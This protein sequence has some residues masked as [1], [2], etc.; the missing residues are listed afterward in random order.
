MKIIL[1]EIDYD[2]DGEDIDL[3]KEIVTSPEE[4]GYDESEDGDLEEY[5]AEHG[6]DYI[7]DTTGWL[8][9]G[10]NFKIVD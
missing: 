7:S 5:I 3:P 1:S 9:E 6:A 10:F 4:M 8:V 2:T